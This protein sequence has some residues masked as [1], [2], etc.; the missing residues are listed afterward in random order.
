MIPAPDGFIS[1][2]IPVSER[3]DSL[4]ELYRDYSAPLRAAGRSFEFV[5]VSE[6]WYS[7]VTAPLA[8]LVRDGEPIRVLEVG[9]RVGEAALLKLAA[10]HARGDIL[11]TLP[12]YRR[13]QASALMDLVDLVESDVDLAVA[14]RWPRKDS[15][16]N[17]LQNRAFHFMVRRMAGGRFRDLA[18]GVRAMRREVLEKMP[19]YGDFFR[20]LPLLAMREGFIVEEI[21]APQHTGDVQPRVYSPGTYLRRAID[22]VGVMFIIRFTEKPLRFFGLLGSALSAVGGVILMWL[23]VERVQGIGVADRPLLLLGVLFVVLGVQA[24]ALGLIGEIIV[25]LHSPRRRS[26]RI[27]RPIMVGRSLPEPASPPGSAP[28]S[29]RPSPPADRPLRSGGPAAAPLRP[30]SGSPP[31]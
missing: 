15:W 18:C 9:Q 23:F 14:R 31:R 17:R 19:L 28:P 25:Y 7:A 21:S 8:D 12:A 2:L 30:S 13:V 29:D 22:V 11:V 5:I 4:V 10:N 26:Y 6:P 27:A 20:F 3:P 1:V 24:L 16:V